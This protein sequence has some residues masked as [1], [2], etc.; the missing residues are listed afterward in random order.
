MNE[1]GVNDYI[2]DVRIR[3]VKKD[4]DPSVEGDAF[5]FTLPNYKKATVEDEGKK[6]EDRNKLV[7]KILLSERKCFS[8]VIL[9][10]NLNIFFNIFL[11]YLMIIFLS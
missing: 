10:L 9:F 8:F 6:K 7:R 1:V 11:N 5:S 3:I 4:Q 2:S